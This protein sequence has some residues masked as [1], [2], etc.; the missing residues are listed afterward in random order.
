MGEV[1]GTQVGARPTRGRSAA[2]GR[3]GASACGRAGGGPSERQRS[4]ALAERGSRLDADRI[5][6]VPIGG[7]QAI[8][9]FLELFG[10][11]GLEPQAGGTV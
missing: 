7:A 4:T 1:D 11:R 5:S 3:R 6:V 8:G 9:H 10:P 2:G